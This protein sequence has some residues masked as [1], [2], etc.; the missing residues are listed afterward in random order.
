MNILVSGNL[1]VS[2]AERITFGI[3]DEDFEKWRLAD[4]N[5]NLMYYILDNGFELVENVTLPEDYEPGKYFYEDGEFIVN[6]DWQPYISPEERIAELETM[7]AIHEENDAE[8]LFQISLL[9][10]GITED[11]LEEEV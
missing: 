8:L 11:M 5:D 1:I 10:L 3:Y 2:V 7:V 9:Q 6:D 4:E